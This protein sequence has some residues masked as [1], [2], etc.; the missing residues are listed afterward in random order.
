MN[1]PEP[2][3]RKFRD[4]VWLAAGYKPSSGEYPIYDLEDRLVTTSFGQAEFHEA[5]CPVKLCSG[6]VRAGKSIVLSMEAAKHLLIEDGLMWIVGPDYDQCK[7]EFRY[8]NHALQRLDCLAGD[9]STPERGS[10]SLVTKWGFKIQTKS[11]ADLEA[12]A[13]FA[14]DIILIVEANQQPSGVLDKAYERALEKSAPILISGTIERSY[15]WYAEKWAAWQGDNP[16]GAKSFSLPSWSNKVIFP[17]GRDDPKIKELEVRLGP[18]LFLERCA[19]IPCTPSD[20]VFGE[21]STKRHVRKLEFN[22][23][24]P[25]ELAIDPAKHTYAIEVI[26]WET[27][28]IFKW[29]E[30][31]EIDPAKLDKKILAQNRTMVYVIDEIYKH[32]MIAQDIIPIVK[33]KP[34]YSFIKSGV[35][36]NAGKQQQ[37]NKSQ[38]QVWNEETGINLRGKYVFIPEG[39]DVLK[40][41]LRNDPILSTSLIQFDYR[42]D[43]SKS[44]NGRANG[45]LAEFGLYKN[46][47][48]VAG[49]NERPVPIDANNDGLKATSYWCFDRFGP[50]V[51]RKKLPKAITRRYL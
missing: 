18:E 38:V 11:G 40:L 8:L 5:D 24:L 50:V 48:W 47:E 51:E 31:L 36:D 6:G 45:V 34:Y 13:S 42:L 41:R 28:P 46:P 32:G 12:L 10:Q 16:Q 33:A 23:K 27:L 44:D 39:I 17:K 25:I 19:A 37:G 22:P 1:V 14:P 7:A 21:F 30:Q 49:R 3:R 20:L 29:L 26:Q 43:T 15:P 35:V 9:P 2:A 4:A